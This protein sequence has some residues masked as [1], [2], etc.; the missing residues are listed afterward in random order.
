MAS[1]QGDT[2]LHRAPRVIEGV[3]SVDAN[4]ATGDG[5]AVLELIAGW[6]GLCDTGSPG[7]AA[8]VV[9]E[10]AL[11]RAMFDDELGPLARDYAG[12]DAAAEL[13]A[14]LLA[15]DAARIVTTTGQSG[16]PFS[17]HADDWVPLWLEN[18]T[19]ALPF[20]D[21]AREQASADVLVLDPGS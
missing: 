13:A 14:T 6:D 1:I 17:L 10:H 16:H 12:A 18:E 8:F 4:P 21:A 3:L 11:V 15:T 20:S 2:V 5:R 19:V 7:C 9:F